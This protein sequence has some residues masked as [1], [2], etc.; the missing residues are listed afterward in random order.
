M[1]SSYRAGLG[2]AKNLSDFAINGPQAQVHPEVQR[3]ITEV[4]GADKPVGALC[5]APATLTRAIADKQPEVTIGNDQGTADAIEQMGGKHI[6]CAVDQIHTD[7]G[8]KL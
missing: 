7:K 5:I 6:L 2:A 4:I 1:P 8:K 3:I